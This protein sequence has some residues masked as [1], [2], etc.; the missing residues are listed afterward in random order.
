MSLNFTA[1]EVFEMAEHLERDGAQFYRAAADSVTDEKMKDLFYTLSDWEI[2]HEKIFSSLR[3]DLSNKEKSQVTFDPN[4]ESARYLKTLVE[5]MVS[6]SHTL[7]ADSPEEILKASIESERD[8]VKFYTAMRDA[9]PESL[10]KAKID[11]IIDEEASHVKVLSEQ[12][13][14]L[15]G[16]SGDIEINVQVPQDEKPAAKPRP[17]H[18]IACVDEKGK[19]VYAKDKFKES[20]EH[21]KVEVWGED[22]IDSQSV[23]V[24]D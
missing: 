2:R 1:D 18:D 16:H 22:G 3:K 17:Q 13:G 19:K 5:G 8:A 7:K 20:G 14:K 23:V 6:F 21:D 15:I 9:V 12:L 4:D 24:D 10:G 11:K